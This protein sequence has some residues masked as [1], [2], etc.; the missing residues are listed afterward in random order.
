MELVELHDHPEYLDA[1][2]HILNNEWKRSYAARSHSLSKSSSNLPASLALVRHR[3]GLD[4]QV[5]G[6]AKLCRV[7]HD[8]EACFVESVIVI[9]EERGQGFGK[10]IMNL[11]EEY[12]RKKGFTRCYLSTHDKEGFYKAIG[13]TTCSP[14]CGISGTVDHTN[15]VLKLFDG[16]PSESPSKDKSFSDDCSQKSSEPATQPPPPPPT[17]QSLQQVKSTSHVW[18]VK[19]L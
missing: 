15:R 6:H 11:T 12:A 9:P 18:L 16:K 4:S 13:Y 3:E 14:V 19:E 8:D 7:L 1:C 2:C 17:L 5:I 10:L